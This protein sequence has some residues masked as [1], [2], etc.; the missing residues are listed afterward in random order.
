MPQTMT[1]RY[2]YYYAWCLLLLGAAAESRHEAYSIVRNRLCLSDCVDGVCTVDFSGA[3]S[4]CRQTRNFVKHYRSVSNQ[5]CTSNC[6]PYDD[7][8]WQQHHC[9]VEDGR[10]EVCNRELGLRAREVSLTLN[11]YQS[12]ID[13]CE[14]RGRDRAWCYVAGGE[15]EYCVPNRRELLVDYRT[16]V[17]T[18]CKSPCKIDTDSS[19]R[20]YD[21]T[22]AWRQCT[23]NPRYH[24]ELQRVHDFVM[25]GGDLGEFGPNGYRRCSAG[26]RRRQLN[27]DDYFAGDFI[28]PDPTTNASD[29]VFDSTGWIPDGRGNYYRRHRRDLAADYRRDRLAEIERAERRDKSFS[30]TT[31]L[32]IT[33]DQIERENLHRANTRHRIVKRSSNIGFDV[34]RVARLYERNNPSVATNSVPYVS[35]TVLPLDARFGDVAENVPLTLRGLV[36][37]HNLEFDIHRLPN[38]LLMHNTTGAE[39]YQHLNRQISDFVDT[40]STRYAEVLAV[41]IYDRTLVQKAVGLRVRLYD[42]YQL[43]ALDGTP[44]HSVRDNPMENMLFTTTLEQ[45]VC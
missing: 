19:T 13:A 36:T 9:V 11:V 33:L 40:S 26:R 25:H 20:C 28:L 42:G 12:C 5:N 7:E 24:D 6:G 23:L 15:R 14:K 37:K 3:I 17:G 2:C 10:R 43:L 18:V 22:G 29:P 21:L 38:C 35:Y 32:E 44:V 8:R 31:R 1:N 16:D 41:Y 34:E 39:R 45:S 30:T 27:M 4:N